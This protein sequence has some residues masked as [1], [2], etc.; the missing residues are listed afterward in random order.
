MGY[1]KSLLYNR[2]KHY[3]VGVHYKYARF[4]IYIGE[5]MRTPTQ[6]LSYIVWERV[7]N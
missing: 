6:N 7:S 3:G 2:G 4:P 1:T 5:I